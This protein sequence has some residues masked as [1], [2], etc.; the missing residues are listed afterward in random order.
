MVVKA[1]HVVTV[2]PTGGATTHTEQDAIMGLSLG[3]PWTQIQHEKNTNTTRGEN[4]YNM[5]TTH[6]QYEENTNT[7]TLLDC[8]GMLS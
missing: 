4:K 6:I 2:S 8:L 5:R 1:G 7:H 3:A